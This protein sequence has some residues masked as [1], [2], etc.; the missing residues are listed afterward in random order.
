MLAHFAVRMLN[1]R[2][3]L[4]ATLAWG[5]AGCVSISAPSSADSETRPRKLSAQENCG[6]E[7][8]SFVPPRYPSSAKSEGLTGWGAVI[9]DLDGSGHAQNIRVDNGQS[10]EVFNAS[11]ARSVAETAYRA[12]AARKDCRQVVRFVL[13]P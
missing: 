13:H 5:A 10:T 7:V 2:L 12:G 11:V 6:S 3:F 1:C 8:A 9:F 4:I